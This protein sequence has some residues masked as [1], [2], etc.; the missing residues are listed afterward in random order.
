MGV[1]LVA[2]WI[3]CLLATISAAALVWL[4][5]RLTAS[6]SI[7]PLSVIAGVCVF[8]ALSWSAP[9]E[10]LQSLRESRRTLEGARRTLDV[11]EAEA[12]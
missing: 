12:A 4:G 11:E 1:A 2:L 3:A 9:Q 5:R 8:V 7:A 6:R 10:L